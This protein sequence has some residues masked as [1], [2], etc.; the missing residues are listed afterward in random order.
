M[1]KASW[2]GCA[3][4]AREPRQFMKLQ[5]GATVEMCCSAG[6]VLKV[7]MWEQFDE[8]LGR[9]QPVN[10]REH[11]ECQNCGRRLHARLTAEEATT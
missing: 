1:S 11:Y 10:M 7:T 4:A 8:G 9:G 3:M 6:G 5:N 2:Y